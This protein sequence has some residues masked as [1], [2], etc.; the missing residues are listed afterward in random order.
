MGGHSNSVIFR[1]SLWRGQ[2][3]DS[4]AV[5]PTFEDIQFALGAG[6]AIVISKINFTITS[7]PDAGEMRAIIAVTLDESATTLV[8][9]DIE[10]NPNIVAS[11]TFTTDITTSGATTLSHEREAIF[12]PGLIIAAPILRVIGVRLNGSAT[13]EAGAKIHFQRAQLSDPDLVR[14]VALRRTGRF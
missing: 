8:L 4:L 2:H 9:A 6:E 13:V 14:A 3:L 12:D 11:S 7:A 10:Q 1:P 5:G